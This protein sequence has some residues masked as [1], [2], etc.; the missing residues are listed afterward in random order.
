M[1]FPKYD[2]IMASTYDSS[3]RSLVTAGVG[4]DAVQ[5]SVD[6]PIGHLAKVTLYDVLGAPQDFLS[7]EGLPIPSGG[8]YIVHEN[9]LGMVVVFGYETEE[10][11]EFDWQVAEQESLKYHEDCEA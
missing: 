5:G 9:Q 2:R 6:E 7:D 10:D 1:E 4:V 11:R 8:L 3:F